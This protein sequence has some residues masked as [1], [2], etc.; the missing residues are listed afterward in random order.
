MPRKSLRKERAR[1]ATNTAQHRAR[2]SAD[3]WARAEMRLRSSTKA[4]LLEL[5]PEERERAVALGIDT[6]QQ[7]TTMKIYREGNDQ[8]RVAEAPINGQ[9]W[10]LVRRP[11]VGTYAHFAA[12]DWWPRE[13]GEAPPDL[14]YIYEEFGEGE[15]REW[16]DALKLPELASKVRNEILEHLDEIPDEGPEALKDWFR[17]I[18]I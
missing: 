6:L 7:D 16:V 18:V 10:E 5:A 11:G 3:G 1:K 9:D 13:E 12:P 14:A 17:V 4:R 2:I 8:Y 15:R